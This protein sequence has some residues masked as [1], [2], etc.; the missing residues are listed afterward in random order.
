M[1]GAK[2]PG[3]AAEA[4]AASTGGLDELAGA[5]A[6]LEHESLPVS[7]GGRGH[8]RVGP[9]SGH[10]KGQALKPGQREVQDDAAWLAMRFP[11]GLGAVSARIQQRGQALSQHLVLERRGPFAAAE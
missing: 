5:A 6:R 8:R 4:M 3:L 1:R 11:V 9:H 2:P 7:P 10:R